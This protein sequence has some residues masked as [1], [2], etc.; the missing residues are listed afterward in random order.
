[1]SNKAYGSVSVINVNDG[2]GI[3]QTIV[4]YCVGSSATTPPGNPIT[5]EQGNV[6]VDIEGKVLTDG[7]WTESVPEVQQGMYLWGRLVTIYDNGTFSVLYSISRAGEDGSDGQK[8]DK[9]DTG[10]SI[11]NVIPEYYLSTSSSELQGGSWSE[12]KPQVTA[13]KY[14]WTRQKNILSNSTTTYSTAICDITITGILFD[15]NKLNQNI[16]SKIWQSDITSSI[17]EYDGTTGKGIRD[18]VTQTEEDISGL[19]S[20]VSDIE[21]TVSTKADG[22][23]VTALT[24]RVSASE[25][26]VAGFKNTVAATYAVKGDV[27]EFIVGTQT[28]STAI[29]TGTSRYLTSLTDGTQ[30][31]Y[32]LPYGYSSSD[33]YSYTPNSGS[34]A[35]GA[36]LRLTF[37]DNTFSDTIPCFYSGVSRLTSHYAAGNII[38]FVYREN[39]TIGSATVAKGW[40]ADSDYNTNNYDRMKF[41]GQVKAKTTISRYAIAVS[42]GNGFYNL[43]SGSSFSV[44][45]PILY[46]QDGG[47]S[48]NNSASYG[49][50]VYP[51]TISTTQAIDLVPGKPL[52]IK[53]TLSGL[54]F[55]P[56]SVAPITQT[57]PISEDGY[58]YMFLGTAYGTSSTVRTFYLLEDHPIYIYR[59]GMGFVR[60]E[61]A[62]L[63]V[64]EQTAEGFRWIVSSGTSASDFQLTDRT[65]DLVAQY[66]NL[67]GK[68]TFNGLNSNTQTLINNAISDAQSATSTANSATTI[69]NNANTTATNV[70]NSLNNLEIGGRNLALNTAGVIL[71]SL[72][73]ASG[74]KKEYQSFNL[75]V[76]LPV[77]DGD[78]ICISFDLYM[79][80]NSAN[81]YLFVYNSNI[82]G[83]H[84]T[85]TNTNV[86]G[87]ETHPVGEIINR[88]ISFVVTIH[89]RNNADKTTDWIEFYS[90]Y[91]SSNWYSI[92]NLKIERGNRPTDWT[93][94]PEDTES[95]ISSVVEENIATYKE[96]NSIVIGTQTTATAIF[97]GVAKFNVLTDGKEITY[98]LPQA[99]SSNDAVSY[100]PTGGSA[101]SGAVLNL[102]L[103][104]GTS[105]GNIPCF[106][107]GASRLTS[108]YGA[109]NVIH[110]LYRENV[111]IGS[112]TINKGFWAD[113]N[114]D[115]NT[116]D[117]LRYSQN[118]TADSGGITSGNIIVGYNGRYHNL[119]TGGAFDISYPILYCGTTLNGNASGNNNYL[120][121]PFNSSSTQNTSWTVGKP[122][123]IRG[124]LNGTT[125]TPINTTPLIQTTPTSNDGYQYILLGNAYATN[126]IYLAYDHGIYE[127]YDGGFKSVNQI[128]TEAAIKAAAAQTTANNAKNWIDTIGSNAKE[129][130]ATWTN[131]ATLATTVIDGGYI[132]TH[133]IESEHLATDAIMSNNF[134]ASQNGSSPYSAVGSFLN[135]ENGNFYTQ[136]FGID[137][138]HGK[139]YING[140]IIADSGSIGLD[141]TNY[142]EIG[143][144]TDYNGDD[145]AALIGHGSSF[146]QSGWWQ[147]SDNRINTQKYTNNHTLT[148]LTNN[149]KYYDYGMKV[150]S[151]TST[152]NGDDAWLYIRRSASNTIPTIEADW[153]YLFKVDKD[154]NVYEGGVKLSEKYA[155]ISD[156]GSA[157]VPTSGGTITGNLTVN[158]TLT[159]TATKA[160]ELAT[161]RTIRT[162]L[163]STSAASFNGSAN[164]TPGVTGTLGVGNGGTGQT[165]LV[166]GA[167]A[168]LPWAFTFFRIHTQ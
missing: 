42:D 131:D 135:L 49:Y 58:H 110:F 63:T 156:V 35:V 116:Y 113:A 2:T 96:E 7:E 82:K 61:T 73:S 27:S 95:Q 16:T 134:V 104:N 13:N 46:M 87:G 17:N 140:E 137:N 99:Y 15:V 159:A 149:S 129:I 31:T 142:W 48:A 37:N 125:F 70:Q 79:T 5:D 88:R 21:T 55:A 59:N 40:W 4:T 168:F 39:V 86:L 83:P 155:L 105:T 51:A 126:G 115:S 67:N 1:M 144:F 107:S 84:I 24:Q 145:S 92:S 33:A 120:C 8:G 9:G 165:T 153:T 3:K 76:S 6:L 162:N 32:W 34:S 114:Y 69:A 43:N 163:A 44:N 130:L 154:G 65:A 139:A 101:S 117:R 141:D 100:T 41:N 47:I 166:N 167:N 128:A 90:T 74:S 94:A 78:D 112:V 151:F 28:G 53:G 109:G 161:A 71:S 52:Y 124:T 106:Y 62:A 75:G 97:T 23:T 148:Y 11:V 160:N 164:I 152:T 136:N 132:K 20:T 98:W 26:D 158:G 147:I 45:C 25:Q 123:Y 12:T 150:P 64:A 108:H 36:A 57:Q 18:R 50:V 77:S 56:Y 10:T 54:T 91:G 146:L 81:P 157:Y 22:S 143:T 111:T 89:D 85:C 29:F 119:K 68:V 66:I 138:T 118:I 72:G 133:T 80:V 102:T 14:I 103:G 93:P 30:I 19:T 121:I 38:R 60:V 127:Y 122:V